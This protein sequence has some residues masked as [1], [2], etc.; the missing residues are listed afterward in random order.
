VL[1]LQGAEGRI[2]RNHSKNCA[3]CHLPNLDPTIITSTWIPPLYYPCQ[4]CQRIDDA[5]QMLFCDNYNGGYHFFCLKAKLIQI[6]TS[7]WYCS[8][9]SPTAPCSYSNHAMI[10]PAQV[11][12][13]IHEFHLSLLLCIVYIYICAC[14]SFW[15]I[16]LYL[17]LVLIFLFSRVYYGFIPLRHCTSR[18]YTSWQLSCPY[19]ASYMMGNYG[20]AHVRF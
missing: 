1:E 10:F 14:I 12:G 3:P 11:W 6:S 2:I 5:N 9:C 18:H 8:S 13:G 16:S 4:V 20:H 19:M 17:W 15:L 7:N